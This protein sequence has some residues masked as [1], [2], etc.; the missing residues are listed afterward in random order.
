[1]TGPRTHHPEFEELIS[2]SLAGDLSDAERRRLDAHLDGCAA[3][4]ETL[5]SFA[6]G[7]R[8][9]AGLR[10][11]PVPRDLHARVRAG[12]ERGRFA[13][14][15]WWRRPAA[16]FAGVGG[17]LAVVAGAL[18]AIVV[19]SERE[20][21]VGQA[22]PT[23]TTTAV[24]SATPTTAPASFPSGPTPTPAAATALPSPTETAATPAP[25]PTATPSP[26]P[27][28][29][30][31]M[32]GP[33]DNRALT[34]REAPGGDLVTEVETP[35][36][37]PT[38]AQLSPDGQWIAYITPVGE[39]GTHEVR[40]TRI[41]EGTPVEDPDA[42][43]PI[44]SP[45]PVGETVVLG[46]SLSGDPFLEQIFWSTPRGGYL[47]YTLADPETGETD[48]WLFEPAAGNFR[49]LTDTGNAYA[50]SFVPGGGAG[51]SLLWVS[52]AGET[53]VSFLRYFHD[54]AGGTGEPVDPAVDA[55]ATAEGVFQPLLSPNGGLA[56]YW[57][58]AMERT[59]D[60]WRFVSGS[61]PYLAEHR[62]ENAE[63]T[64]ENEQRMFRDLTV[65]RDGFT[66]ASIV[67]G[68]DGDA[69]AV[70]DARWTGV[71]QSGAGEDPYPDAERVYFGRATDPRGVTRFHAIDADDIPEDWSVV[72]VKI[73]PTGEHL[74][75]T[76]AEPRAGTLDAATARLLLVERNTGDKADRVEPI[77]ARDGHWYGPA[78]FD[79]S[80]A[81][82]P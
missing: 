11:V 63:A 82:R 35:P 22:T 41:A 32:T 21:Q 6:G 76:V 26:E 78:T 53:P 55:L 52:A 36:G 33:A 47:A 46:E 20:P 38:S 80:G 2:A 1:M 66:S 17:S 77:D 28:V 64:F 10:H 31:A 54:D 74:V 39:K 69:Y 72:D 37:P 34:V 65:G 59:G 49:Q 61:Q 73:A 81:D 60:S 15:P 40:A 16:I 3:C 58:G 42:L 62:W 44:D 5:T 79:R 67:W 19:L 27:D 13:T 70:W 75:I 68:E 7:R 9:V 57:N 12:V 14:R 48:V 43:P 30:L 4:R 29:Y 8:I 45:V 24:F 23:P 18:L 50:A 56:I 51:A 71:P 25:T